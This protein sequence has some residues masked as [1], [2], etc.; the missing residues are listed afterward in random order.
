FDTEDKIVRIEDPIRNL[1]DKMGITF[2]YG[3]HTT[4]DQKRK[5][6]KILAESL[7]E[8]LD[9]N[10]HTQIA[11][12]LLMTNPL[13]YDGTIDELMFSGGVAEYIYTQTE[14]Y[15]GDLGKYLGEE[16]LNIVKEKNISIHKPAELIR[17]TVIGA[18]QYTLQVSGVTTHISDV[19]ILPIHNIPVLEPKIN[20][21]QITEENVKLAIQKSLNMFDVKEGEEIVALSFKGAIGGSYAGLTTFAKGV[22]SALPNTIRKENPVILVFD[23]DIGNSVG[24]VM[25]R[26]TSA[27]KNI[28]SVDEIIIQEG[29]FIDIDK[30]KAGGQVVPVVVKSLVFSA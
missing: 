26:E 14:E 22:V 11:K 19:D 12:N 15:F 29:D 7:F 10:L 5:M 17:A 25:K 2:E 9:R 23:R 16:I 6:A 13:E 28:I 18:G 20:N 21:K 8:T 3:D 1:E 27:K 24:N 4:I 30:P